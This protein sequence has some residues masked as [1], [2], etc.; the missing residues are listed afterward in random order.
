MDGQEK[1][2]RFEQ[3]SELYLSEV[4][5]VSYYFVRDEE[6]ASKIT[7]KAFL[8]FYKNME[9]IREELYK[10]T[11]IC[12]AKRLAEQYQKNK[13]SKGGRDEKKN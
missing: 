9:N 4:Y 1:M 7:R 2:K 3:V 10:A 11:L 8:E 5:R 6:V 12:G 13:D